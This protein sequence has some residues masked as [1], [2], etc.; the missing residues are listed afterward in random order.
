MRFKVFL[1]K[2][3]NIN[4]KI[5]EKKI[6]IYFNKWKNIH[7]VDN[8]DKNE[9]KKNE[10]NK[11]NYIEENQKLNSTIKNLIFVLRVNLIYFSLNNKKINT[12]D[13]QS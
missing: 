11:N 6:K 12:N 10:I 8:I 2:I 1:E 3:K 5:F 13:S 7:N 9:D 4:E